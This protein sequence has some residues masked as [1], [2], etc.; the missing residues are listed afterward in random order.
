MLSTHSIHFLQ[1]SAVVGKFSINTFTE[2][3][4]CG[5]INT[6]V[7]IKITITNNID[8]NIKKILLMALSSISNKYDK[9]ITETST[10]ED[11]NL[12][13]EKTIYLKR[14]DFSRL[15]LC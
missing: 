3:L 7:P 10:I 13:N 8:K 6:I 1:L 11:K 15:D 9:D 4:I 14:R 5:I 2:L 12:Q